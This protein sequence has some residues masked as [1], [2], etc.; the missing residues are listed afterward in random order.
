MGHVVCV[1]EVKNACRVSTGEYESRRHLGI[2]RLVYYDNIKMGIK[3][4]WLKSCR[5]A[6]FGPRWR[7]FTGCC[8]RDDEL[9]GSVKGVECCELW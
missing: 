3:E 8:E 5:L 4:V 2:P 1:G 6:Y 7:S 9:P